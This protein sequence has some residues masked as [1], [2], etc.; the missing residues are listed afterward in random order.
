MKVGDGFHWKKSGRM[1]MKPD[2]AEK[3]RG[4]SEPSSGPTYI[5]FKMEIKSEE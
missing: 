2:P 5:Q 4:A 3:W 1:S